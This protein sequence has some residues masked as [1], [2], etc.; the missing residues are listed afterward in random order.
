MTVAIIL[1]LFAL[2]Q[3]LVAALNYFVRP[4]LRKS[5]RK[6]IG[7]VSVL[8][9]ARNEEKNIMALLGDL[10]HQ[11]YKNIEII[12]FNDASTDRTA[13]FVE[14][15]SKHD[16]RIQLIS[17]YSLKQGWLGK[18]FACHQ[19]AQK[20]KGKYLLFLDADV[21]IDENA[22]SASLRYVMKKNLDLLS[23]FPKQIMNS[24]GERMVVP[25]MNFILVTLL[26][27]FLVRKSGF[28]SLA[29]ANGQFMLFDAKTYKKLLPHEKFKANKVEDIAIAQYFKTQK[30]TI[31]CLLSPDSV[32]CQMYTGYG[33]AINGFAKNIVSFFGGSF[34]V[35]LLFW[36]VSTFSVF[37]VYAYLPIV[38]FLLFCFVLLVTRY[39]VSA[40]SRQNV[41]LNL[42]LIVPQQLNIFIIILKSAYNKYIRRAYEWK[43][44]TV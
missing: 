22:L 35:A 3:L 20:A 39:F 13:N 40:A 21:R 25:I 9:P 15:M 33:D 18:N 11:T 41:G 36:L 8:I 7:L 34:L 6:D 27:L 30:R 28:K 4:A 1:F 42:L 5:L 43:G 38:Y 26:P 23:F 16:A 24:L 29:A 2:L 32:R 19:M 12:V 44:R 17:S 37:V 31:A 14:Q 10:Q